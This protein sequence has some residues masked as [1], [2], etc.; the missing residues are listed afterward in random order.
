[1]PAHVLFTLLLMRTPALGS[2]GGQT[3]DI[4]GEAEEM[5]SRLGSHNPG[6]GTT[7]CTR[8]HS[9]PSLTGR[10][11][12]HHGDKLAGRRGRGGPWVPWE[13]TAASLE[14]FHGLAG[15]R[16]PPLRTQ[17]A[18]RLVPVIRRAAWLRDLIR[19]CR[20]GRGPAVGPSETLTATPDIKAAHDAGS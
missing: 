8:G 15:N 4:Q 9:G 10:T 13:H 2:Q 17:Q 12:R 6:E 1:M 5:D 11:S 16:S 19:G 7:H 20:V 3:P 18:L 14:E